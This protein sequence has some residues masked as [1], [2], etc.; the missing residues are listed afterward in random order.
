MGRPGG[1]SSA[2]QARTMLESTKPPV[3]KSHERTV[4]LALATFADRD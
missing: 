2:V 3:A 4:P 1:P